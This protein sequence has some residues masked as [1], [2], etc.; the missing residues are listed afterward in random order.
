MAGY[1][2]L[3][4]LL[5]PLPERLGDG[6][7]AGLD[8]VSGLARKH[9]EQ[10]DRDLLEMHLRSIDVS[11]FIALETGRRDLI[12]G[13]SLTREELAGAR[14]LPGI[15]MDFSKEREKGR[16]RVYVYDRLWESYFRESFKLAESKKCAFLKRYIPWEIQLRNTLA[17]ARRS[18]APGDN[19][20]HQVLP[21]FQ[22]YDMEY[23]IS[24]LREQRSPLEQER[25]LDR[26]RLRFIAG[27]LDHDAFSLDA[28][29]G[30]LSRAMV[31]SRWQKAEQTFPIDKLLN[32]GGIK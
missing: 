18:G 20:Q 19:E 16:G 10:P 22:D 3:M 1:Y 26:E 29:L 27:C 14:G 11:N 25:Y 21:Q 23:L 15:F 8:A 12:P 13:G 2:F 5:P 4:S 30:Y 28:L 31:F 6:L 7:K 24:G 32:A 17:G 9:A